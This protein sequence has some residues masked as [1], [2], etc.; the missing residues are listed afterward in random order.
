MKGRSLQR[1]PVAVREDVLDE[2]VSV[3]RARDSYGV[4]FTGSVEE[5]DL[6]VDV[7]ATAALRREGC[8]EETLPAADAPGVAALMRG[9]WGQ[10]RAWLLGIC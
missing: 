6:E 4:V 8:L 10:L 9:A 5:F 3:Q 2:I 1:D 7:E